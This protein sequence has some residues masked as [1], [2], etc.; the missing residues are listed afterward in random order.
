M[1]RAR[2]R[3]LW[4][5]GLITFTLT[6]GFAA[7]GG[8]DGR[9]V[10]R[11]DEDAAGGEET[12]GKGTGG[13]GSSGS[14][15]DA[16]GTGGMDANGGEPMDDPN[17]FGGETSGGAPP[18]VDGPPEVLEV[19]PEDGTEEVEPTGSVAL[20]FSE[21]LDEATVTS[22][23]IQ[24]LDGAEPVAGELAY[25][26]VVSTFTPAHRLSLL[27]TYD[28]SVS[29]AVSDLAGQGLKEPFTSTFT[30]RDGA[31]SSQR[32]IFTD[33]SMYM[34][35]QDVASDARGNSLFVWTTNANDQ[36]LNANVAYAR[37]Y[38]I[39][40]G[41]KA[42]VKL[43]D[44]I[45][46]CENLR[47][48]VSAEGD[49]VVAW[50]TNG[51]LV[52][53]RRFVSGTWER[54]AQTLWTTAST[55]TPN[56]SVA[57]GGGQVLVAWAHHQTIPSN[58]WLIEMSATAVDAAW[59]TVPTSNYS[60]AVQA[61]NNDAIR[62]VAA[63]VDNAGAALVVFQHY[64]AVTGGSSPRGMYY[65]RKAPRDD[66][67]Y[68]TKIPSSAASGFPV[69]ASDGEGAMAIWHV[70]TAANEHSI[71]ASRYTKAK[72][73]VAPTTI[74]DP[75]LK[76]Y[77]FTIG[78][79]NPSQLR[80]LAGNRAGFFATWAQAV[81]N[82]YNTYATHFDI[83]T[84]KW[85]A[86]P[87]LVSDGTAYSNQSQA[88]GVDAHGNALVTF[89]QQGATTSAVM[90]ARFTASIGE[91][92]VAKPLTADGYDYGFPQLAVAANGVASVFFGPPYRDAA[93]KPT[94]RGQYRIF[95]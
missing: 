42:E 91:W 68:P 24:I 65:A 76:G 72:Q 92:S 58:Y 50:T 57:I 85:D 80:I 86:L 29:D 31:W 3:S 52:R 51:G 62:G 83:E 45:D 47:L 8:L 19:S 2:Q 1:K 13:K 81:G 84:A 90:V 71:V 12:G 33:E 54:E 20:R 37:W 69:L 87:A 94:A 41:L 30:V 53:A 11:G 28:V 22:D 66:W 60:V 4:Q 9:I 77:I 48:A 38:D 64:T 61:A 17:P 78:E 95:K 7:C 88:I 14:T 21:G 26:G 5:A 10:T 89:D 40:T 23:N 63:A 79:G 25:S 34:A 43:D 32:S 75:D 70:Q 49:A 55:D 36:G 35:P 18:V 6:L 93:P 82:F 46:N 39:A 73:F 27:A 67:E 16:P 74:S 15:G 59:P 56:P 44:C